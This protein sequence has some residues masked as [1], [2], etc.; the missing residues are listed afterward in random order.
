MASSIAKRRAPA[1]A[2]IPSTPDEGT[3]VR[4]KVANLV[5]SKINPRKTMDAAKVDDLGDQ[6][7]TQGLIH[8]LTVRSMT[9]EL[10]P[11][12]FE[13]FIGHRRLAA[14]KAKIADGHLPADHEANCVIRNVDDDTAF[15]LA[16]AENV[17]R[18]SM[19]PLEECDAI[20]DALA[21]KTPAAELA[22]QTGLKLVDIKDR[23]LVAASAIEIRELVDSEQ[24]S[25]PWAA[26]F[27]QLPGALQTIVLD[28]M[29]RNANSFR[30]IEDLAHIARRGKVPVSHALFDVAASGLA[31]IADLFRP[32]D[33]YF[34]D[35][36]AFWDRQ[37]IAIDDKVGEL[38]QTGQTVEVLRSKPF[39]D[40]HWRRVDAARGAH[41]FIVVA[42]DGEVKIYD[43]LA[44]VAAHDSQ[45]TDHDAAEAHAMDFDTGETD[46]DSAMFEG[47]QPNAAPQPAVTLTTRPPQRKE[48]KLALARMRV[49]RAAAAL[50]AHPENA[51]RLQLAAYLGDNR[52]RAHARL[53]RLPGQKLCPESDDLYAYI[54]LIDQAPSGDKAYEYAMNLPIADVRALNAVSIALRLENQRGA[55]I[56]FAP[57]AIVSEIVLRAKGSARGDYVPDETFFQLF[58]IGELR[59]LARELLSAHDGL[60]AQTTKKADLARLMA[61]R[62]QEAATNKLDPEIAYRL[63]E[64]WPQYL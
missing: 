60:A 34:E 45:S 29:S 58:E 42:A 27:A 46:D 22:R 18:E 41:A 38:E 52:L 43:K 61:D 19:R 7:V 39:I 37:N 3:I 62:F 63:N 55:E 35:T 32:E 21:R 15:L 14:L 1:P 36:A 12:V 5:P 13:V 30:T 47:S 53:E 57:D 40:D 9:D 20:A 59:A 31:V 54:E 4:M 64:W 8:P 26:R 24:R 2:A 28:E 44:P 51:E 10:S 50:I 48:A 49:D 16:L 17:G 23:A 6:I 11:D 33:G 56:A 25:V